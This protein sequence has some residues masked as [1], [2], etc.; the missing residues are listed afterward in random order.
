MPPP[1]VVVLQSYFPAGQQR[2]P[3]GLAW[4]VGAGIDSN[5]QSGPG[6]GVGQGEGYGRVF[7]F[8]PGHETVPTFFNTDV[9]RV[10][11]NAVRW[12]AKRT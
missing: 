1:A 12:V 4:T 9:R 6:R 10:I 5:F 8:R 11:Y 7:Y 2:F 3:S